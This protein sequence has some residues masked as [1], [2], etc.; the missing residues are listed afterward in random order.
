M[1]FLDDDEVVARQGAAG[2]TSILAT[3]RVVDLEGLDTPPGSHA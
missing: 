3:L 2:R 1:A